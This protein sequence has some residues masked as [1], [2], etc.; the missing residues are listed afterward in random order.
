[1]LKLDARDKRLL[2]ELDLNSRQSYTKLGKR[3]RLSPQA[4]EH[5]IKRL[6][7]NDII[8]FFQTI[9][10]YQ[11]LGYTFY[12][13]YTTFQN[14]IPA[15]EDKIINELKNHSKIIVLWKCEGKYDLLIGVLAKSVFELNEILNDISNKSGGNIKDYDIVT[16]IGAKHYDRIYL[17]N[18]K[19]EESLEIVTGGKARYVELDETD[20]NILKILI[21]NPRINFVDAADKLNST[22]DI[23][24]HRYKKLKKQEILQG[25]G[26]IINHEKAGYY[27]YR[28]LFKLKNISERRINEIYSFLEKLKNIKFATKCFG[29]Y[30][31][32]MDLEVESSEKFRSILSEFRNRFQDLIH[33]YD[34]IRIY[35]IEKFITMVKE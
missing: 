3:I 16:H 4:V 24:R 34:I 19:R 14:T 21:E 27:H 32:T 8:R 26:I 2:Y 13:I 6:V 11:K 23:L 12:S 15:K 22:T 35:S 1:M 20:R 10:A 25:F 18:N 17:I 33:H 30:E 31:F 28:V 5:R 9:I 7:K 29:N